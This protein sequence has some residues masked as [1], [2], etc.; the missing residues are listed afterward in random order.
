MFLYFAH[1][2]ALAS[3][4][5]YGFAA[6]TQN[7]RGICVTTLNSPLRKPVFSRDSDAGNFSLENNT[8]ALL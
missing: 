8:T 5:F 1:D 3:I 4:T 2:T 6:S 7:T